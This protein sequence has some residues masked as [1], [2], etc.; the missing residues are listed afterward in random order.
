MFLLTHFRREHR[1]ELAYLRV[2]RRLRHTPIRGSLL[3]WAAIARV[4]PVPGMTGQSARGNG[5]RTWRMCYVASLDF[6]L[7]QCPGVRGGFRDYLPLTPNPHRI[8]LKRIV[9]LLDRVSV[10]R[11]LDIGYADLQTLVGDVAE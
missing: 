3:C 10:S 6:S 2:L 1:N 9:R 8:Q 7:V 5:A 4:R 11:G